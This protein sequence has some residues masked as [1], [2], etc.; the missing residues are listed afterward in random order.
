M[1][2]EISQSRN[3]AIQLDTRTAQLHSSFGATATEIAEANF[4]N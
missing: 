4:L 2:T 3:Q 1:K